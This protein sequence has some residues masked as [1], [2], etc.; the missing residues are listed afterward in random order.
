[1]TRIIQSFATTVAALLSTFAVHSQALQPL[2]AFVVS[3]RSRNP[4]NRAAAATATQS[5]AQRDVATASYLP[6][7]T[8]QGTYTHNQYEASL[9]LPASIVPGG[10]TLVIAPQNQIDAYLTLAVPLINVGAWEQRRAARIHAD[11]TLAVQANTEAWVE[12]R[13]AQAYYQ[14]LG[15]EAVLS[16]ATNSLDAANGNVNTVRDRAQLGTASE[17]DIQRAVA[18]VSRAEQDVATAD[19]GV[20][21][22][23]RS[24]ESL[25]RLTPSP[26]NP[27]NYLPDDLHEERPLA[28]WL[29]PSSAKALVSAKSSVLDTEAAV[30]SRSAARAGWLPTLAAQGQ[31][32]ITNATGFSAR[33]SILT[34]TAT[35]TWRLDLAL[36]PKVEAQSAA[37]AAAEAAEDKAVRAA[38]DAIYE[39]WHHIRVGIAKARAAREQVKANSLAL[40][41]AKDR[42]ANG[43]ALQLEVVQAQR[44]LF[45]SAVAQAQ[46]DF[47]LQYSRALLR[48]AARRTGQ[49]HRP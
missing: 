15:S 29:D 35:A 27:A 39:A 47:D 16:A 42:Y 46:A 28:S 9:T 7:F 6:S 23:R 5:A 30:A 19:Q 31:E 21:I 2:S 3:A 38:Q 11:A 44:D 1:M 48:L 32:H 40:G 10:T 22:A 14:L 25:S 8:A 17:L 43:A 36:A 33:S 13:I 24:L 26:A 49:E 34:V 45:Q 18:D 4:D 12:T 37:L 41:L 20:V